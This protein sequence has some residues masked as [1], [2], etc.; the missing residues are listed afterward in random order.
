MRDAKTSSIA[1]MDYIEEKQA[2]FFKIDA[3]NMTENELTRITSDLQFM[4]NTKD[5]SIIRNVFLEDCVGAKGAITLNIIQSYSVTVEVC[6]IVL[7]N[8]LTIETNRKELM[9]RF[10]ALRNM[11]PDPNG[12]TA[13]YWEVAKARDAA[14]ADFVKGIVH[15]NDTEA[16][17]SASSLNFTNAHTS[18][19][20]TGLKMRCYITGDDDLEEMAKVLW[21]TNTQSASNSFEGEHRIQIQEYVKA[22]AKDVDWIGMTGEGGPCDQYQ[23]HQKGF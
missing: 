10:L 19:A 7:Y 15:Y 23:S 6:L 17:D 11:V 1:I 13:A 18:K 3:F 2:Y 9:E 20:N 4:D 12:V 16:L 22:V 8:Y 14:V 21:N 5:I